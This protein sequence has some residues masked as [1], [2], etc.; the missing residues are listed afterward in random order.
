MPFNVL[1]HW[2]GECLSIWVFV[3]SIADTHRDVS[4]KA[5]IVTSIPFPP[6]VFLK[7]LQ[8]RK[9][10]IPHNRQWH[11]MEDSI[12]K[13]DIFQLKI[14]MQRC[15]G[16]RQ[17]IQTNANHFK[18]FETR[19]VYTCVVRRTLLYWHNCMASF[20]QLEMVCICLNGKQFK[21]LR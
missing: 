10:H 13:L 21:W 18:L 3:F 9:W 1:F 15:F 16:S 7:C 20:K 12:W 8:R 17:P 14:S 2:E 19:P 11:A 4:R 6:H 5:L